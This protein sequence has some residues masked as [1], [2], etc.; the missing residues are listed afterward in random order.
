MTS[1]TLVIMRH[2]KAEQSASL[3]DS[4]R[5]LMPRGRSDA[6][7]A[8]AW[9]AS[10]DLVPIVVLCSPA[11]R[12]RSTW[13]ELA[14]GLAESGAVVAP[15]VSYETDLIYGGVNA[16]LDLVRSLP[17]DVGIALLIGHNPTV[18]A[19]SVRLDDRPKRTAGGLRTAGI[20]VHS[21]AGTWADLATAT[22]AKTHI[23]RAN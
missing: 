8:G 11:V 13:H 20:A 10:K 17:D 6:R 23:A 21:V 14:I 19:L 5:P 7:A 9:L 15:T 12:T 18:S 16:A 1:R 22:L 4:E 2:A 3:P